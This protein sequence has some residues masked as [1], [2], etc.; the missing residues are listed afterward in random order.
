[1]S[2]RMRATMLSQ[3]GLMPTLYGN[4]VRKVFSQKYH[5]DVTVSPRFTFG[6]SVGFKVI[7]NPSVADMRHY[8]RGGKRALWPHVCRITRMVRLESCLADCWATLRA[9]RRRSFGDLGALAPENNLPNS[10]IGRDVH[11]VGHDDGSPERRKVAFSTEVH[12]D[13]PSYR[14]LEW[15][16]RRLQTR[17][18]RL[19]SENLDLRGRLKSVAALCAV[20]PPARPGTPA[21]RTSPPT[22]IIVDPAT[23]SPSR[24]SRVCTKPQSP[25]RPASPREIGC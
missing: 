14:Q 23:S 10:A 2:V 11:G 4:S 25:E 22:Q 18:E 6:E 21:S 20:Q 19:R 5:G 9:E 7:C 1:M 17:L 16:Y 24:A 8:L 3:L 15:E 12:R 13:S